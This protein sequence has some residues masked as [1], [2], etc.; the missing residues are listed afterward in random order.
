MVT[1]ELIEEKPQCPP[2]VLVEDTL[3]H[4]IYH[5][6]EDNQS[7]LDVFLESD[8]VTRA[9]EIRLLCQLN[10]PVSTLPKLRTVTN[11]ITALVTLL[12]EAGMVAGRFE[13]EDLF[14]LGFNNIK[15]TL[16]ILHKRLGILVGTTP[17]LLDSPPATA[18]KAPSDDSQMTLQD[19]EVHP[20]EQWSTEDPWSM[21]GLLQTTLPQGPQVPARQTLQR[22]EPRPVPNYTSSRDEAAREGV[23]T[24]LVGNLQAYFDAAM[25]KFLQER[26]V[27][28]A[29]INRSAARGR[30]RAQRSKA[31]L[32]SSAAMQVERDQGMTDVEM[33]SVGSCEYDPDH[34]DLDG[35]LARMANAALEQVPNMVPRIKLSAT[36]D[37][38]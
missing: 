8:P 29:R 30:K 22:N 35:P 38:K 11:A 2:Y 34:K 12:R 10:E 31:Q 16:E 6:P 28:Q 23:P 14:S 32:G 20:R 33:E 36:S 1:V 15:T 26:Q 18:A 27:P 3:D 13:P 21:R 5:A 19:I 37:L 4:D 17:V 24:N 9:L 7:K 25:A